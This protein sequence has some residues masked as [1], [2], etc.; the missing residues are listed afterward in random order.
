MIALE[1]SMR[2]L[3]RNF[4]LK[5]DQDLCHR[6]SVD[7]EKTRSGTLAQ[8]FNV[9]C[10][11]DPAVLIH[12][13]HLPTLSSFA[14]GVRLRN[15][16]PRRSDHQTTFVGILPPGFTA[17]PRVPSHFNAPVCPYR[18]GPGVVDWAR[19]DFLKHPFNATHKGHSVLLEDGQPA[20]RSAFAGSHQDGQYSTISWR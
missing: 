20:C 12:R 14:S 15:F 5:V 6:L 18:A 13:I 11:T 7:P 16:A 1:I 17:L 4:W 19:G 2:G 8:T 9:A 10:Q 3:L